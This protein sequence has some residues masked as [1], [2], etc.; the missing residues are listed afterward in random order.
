LVPGLEDTEE[1]NRER[2]ETYLRLVAEA[3]LGWARTSAPP[4]GMPGGGHGALVLRQQSAVAAALYDMPRLKRQVLAL[5]FYGDLSEAETAARIGISALAV[6]AHTARGISELRAALEADTIRV[7]TVAL[8]L[9]AVGALGHEAADQILDEFALALGT[10]QGSSAGQRSP[11]PRS[12]LRSP[13]VHLPLGMLM[14]T[15]PSAAS[16]RAAAGTFTAAPAGVPGSAVSRTTAHRAIPVGQMIPVRA[17]RC[18][19]WGE[20]VS[21][22]MYVLSYARTASGA[23]FTMVARSRGEFAPPGIEPSG[24]YRPCG[25]FPA[26]RFT[27]TDDKGTSYRMA[28]S[29]RGGR[30]PSELAGQITLQPAPPSGIRWLDLTTTPG[31]PAVRIDLNPGN[32]GPDG[33]VVTVSQAVTSPGEHLLHTIATRLLLLVLAFPHKIRLHPAALRPRPVTY[34]ADGLGEVIAALQACGA[35]PPLSPVPGQLAALCANLNVTGYGITAPPACGLPEPWLSMLAHY[36][37]RKPGRALG[38]GGCAVLAVA[39]PELDGIR[40]AI[41]GLHNSVDTTFLHVHAG[42][43]TLD[44]GDGS[45]STEPDFPLRI[46]VRDSAG[47]WHATRTGWSAEDDGGVMMHLEL[48]PPLSRATTWIELLAA[49]QSGQL[50]ATLPLRW[51]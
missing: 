26:D 23:R 18:A 2:A 51:R 14:S 45:Q 25:T 33:T 31:E 16:M 41:L 46:W 12:L 20:D 28:F 43:M 44:G 34:I 8:V 10:R 11:D 7:A 39:F 49:G 37:R 4:P 3:E 27:A 19:P 13:A 50:R 47:Q 22:E 32:R 5:Q 36:H 15:R 40:L 9:T 48:V 24:M 30:H 21:G 29:G 42:G 35:L 17:R 6:K 1:M 38:R